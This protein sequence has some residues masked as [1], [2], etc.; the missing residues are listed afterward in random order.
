MHSY[1]SHKW[2]LNTKSRCIRIR[3]TP[4]T[5]TH[6]TFVIPELLYALSYLPTYLCGMCRTTSDAFNL[7]ADFL[8]LLRLRTTQFYCGFM[9]FSSVALPIFVAVTRPPVRSFVIF[10]LYI[11]VGFCFS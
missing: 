9:R 10:T 7:N 11:V 2:V 4:H 5:Q 8:Q 3:R 1:K 6:F